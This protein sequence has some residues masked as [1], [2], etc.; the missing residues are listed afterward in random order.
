MDLKDKRV[1]KIL[2]RQGYKDA[3][4]FYGPL[5][6]WLITFAGYLLAP[7][8][9]LLFGL[10]NNP[11]ILLLLPYLFIAYLFNAYHSCSFAIAAGKCCIIN[12]NWP[13]RKFVAIDLK[14]IES[15]GIK[16]YHKK[17]MMVFA[18]WGSN[19]IEIKSDQGVQCF[20]CANLEA[21]AYDENMTEKTIEDFQYALERAGIPVQMDLEYNKG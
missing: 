8:L 9:G 7:A 10:M 12:P 16:E 5:S 15:V 6:I 19:Y 20:Y 18:F 3:E 1:D 4:V 14:D 21:D 11:W 13:F 2:H 17:W